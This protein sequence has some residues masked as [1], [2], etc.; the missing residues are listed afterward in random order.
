M[1]MSWIHGE[2]KATTKATK[3]KLCSCEES[4]RQKVYNRESNFV[5]ADK[6]LYVRRSLTHKENERKKR[7]SSPQDQFSAIPW[8]VPE[9]PETVL[10][11]KGFQLS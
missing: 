11:L 6:G 5:N 8:R 10:C 3:P 1:F 2:K 9:P 4:K 7:L